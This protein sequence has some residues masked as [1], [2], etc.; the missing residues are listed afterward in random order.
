MKNIS[1]IL[2]VLALLGVATLFYLHFDNK[3]SGKLKKTEPASASSNTFRIAYF[4]IDSLQT[5]FEKFKDAESMLKDKEA[6]KNAELNNYSARYQR[7]LKELQEKAPSMSQAEGE[8]AQRELA[9]MQEN[10]QK[11]QFELDQDMKK[12]QMDLMGDLRKKIEDYL[13]EYNKDKG[14]SFIFSYEPGFMM[15]YKDT[16]YDITQ[17]L[18]A[19]LNEKFVSDQKKK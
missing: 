3:D 11:R 9:Q 19:G 16:A 6:Q 1:T 17:E 2:S 10:Y 5:H 15:Y 18:I 12:M 13:K 14:Y 4:D 7:R 8:A